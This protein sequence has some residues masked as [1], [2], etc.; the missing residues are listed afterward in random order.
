MHTLHKLLFAKLCTCYCVWFWFGQPSL[1][2]P[3]V[4]CKTCLFFE[5]LRI[6]D[7]KPYFWEIWVQ[8][9]FFL[10]VFHLI[11]MHFI[12]KIQYFKEFL[13]KI[14]LF[15]KKLCFPDF[16][17]IESDFWLIKNVIKILFWIWPTRS[18]L[19]QLKVIFDR[20]NLN[21]DRSNLIFD[22]SKIA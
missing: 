8:Y 4:L 15:F 16:W 5:N 19:D 13:Q 22:Q 20:S 12:H 9:K 14:A 10:R 7:W 11:L 18:L 17:S 3:W 2:I 6:I 21:F 1:K